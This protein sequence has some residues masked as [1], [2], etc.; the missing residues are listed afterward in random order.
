MLVEPSAVQFVPS[1][2]RDPVNMFPTRCTFTQYG[3]VSPPVKTFEDPL[4]VLSRHANSMP[5]VGVSAHVAWAEFAASVSRIITP[6]LA[7]VPVLSRL[8]TLATIEQ[9]LVA[10]R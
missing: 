6:T 4:P 7:F 10:G 5:F 3:G 1:A 9:S 2:E 8:A